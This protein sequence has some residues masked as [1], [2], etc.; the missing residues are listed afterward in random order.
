VEGRE[1][2]KLGH[3]K[4]T[5]RVRKWAGDLLLPV[6]VENKA[7]YLICVAGRKEKK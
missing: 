7:D 4:E 5:S 6:V 1:R 3:V 2:R